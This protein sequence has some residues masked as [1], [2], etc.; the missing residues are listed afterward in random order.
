MEG[1]KMK[2]KKTQ[3]ETKRKTI[4]VADDFPGSLENFEMLLGKDYNLKTANC[5][6]NALRVINEGG[7]DFII[8][9]NNMPPGPEGNEI[10]RAIRKNYPSV[11][12]VLFTSDYAEYQHL[13]REGI[14]VMGT[15]DDFFELPDYIGQQ[16]NSNENEQFSCGSGIKFMGGK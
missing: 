16:L 15:E 14:K 7:L 1:M 4:L 5:G 13:E 10:A 2:N 12:V 9:D 6:R 11:P 8:L 3:K